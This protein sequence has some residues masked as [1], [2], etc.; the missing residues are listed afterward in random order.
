MTARTTTFLLTDIEGSTRLWE[1]HGDAMGAALEAHDALLTAA[2]EAA[3]GTV[4]KTTGD[5]VLAAFD[6]P[7]WALEAALGGQR[8][9]AGHAW[10]A[11]GPLRV[12][13]AIHSGSVE[14]RD[15][16]YHG[17]ALNRVARLLA[18]GHGGQVLVSGATA[19]LIDDLPPTVELVDRGEH[20]LRDLDRRE[21]VFQVAAA[22][23]PH[24]FPPLRSLGAH[25]TNLPIQ[26]TSFVGREREL[27]ELEALLARSRLVTLVG[28]GGTGKTRLMLQAAADVV[29]R[30]RDGVW[31]VELAPVQDP[32]LV[33][34]E[35]IRALGVQESPGRRPIDTLI[36]FLRDKE[37]LL[38]LDNC[39]HV[40]AAAA[41]LAQRLL[42]SSPT[43][44]LAASSREP[45]GVGGE[46][47]FPV[48]SLSLPDAP[49]ARAVPRALEADGLEVVARS[50][51]VRLFVDRARAT[52]PGFSLDSANAA[53]V[54]GICRRLDGIPL[55][56][57]LAATRVSVLSVQEIEQRL[58]DRF[59]L[60]T[61]GR[62]TAVPRQQTLQALIDW[63]WDLLTEPDRRRLRRLS[64]FAGGWTL[65]AATA[66][67]GSE[68]TGDDT[69]DGLSR[70]VDRSLVVV[71]HEGSTRYRML[72]TIRQYARERLV[73]SG[74]VAELG[75]AHLAYFR[76]LAQEA[77]VG[78][79]GPEMVRWLDRLDADAD[80]VRTA[81]EWAFETD[82]EAALQL[83]VSLLAYWSLRSAGSESADW[84]GRAVDVAKS[85]PKADASEQRE[86]SILVARTLSAAATAWFWSSR[87]AAR[88]LAES[89]LVIA[90]ET[91]DPLAL[92]DALMSLHFA[93]VFG[94]DLAGLGDW[95]TELERVVEE[96][97]DWWRLSLLHA[98]IA[99]AEARVDPAMAEV[100]LARATEAARR[101]GDPASIAFAALARGRVASY[102]R[103][104]AEARPRFVEAM[105]R[106]LEIGDRRW[107][108]IA[109]SE[110]AHG[111][112]RD[113]AVDEARDEYRQTIREWQRLG[114]R[115]A[116]ANQLECL[117]FVAIAQDDGPRAARLLG[118]AE[119]LREVA[120]ATML[121]IE[122]EEYALEMD[123]L[124]A[125]L[126]AASLAT[127]WA[128]G[129]AL[130]PDAAVAF[131]IE[132]A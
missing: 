55:A 9:L 13:M 41:D 112:R 34:Q 50:E 69:L 118:A 54:A 91:G 99:M 57:E 24:D 102:L 82:P 11:T 90:R 60:L 66:V 45:L 125:G 116:I 2:V 84:L 44:T 88:G 108:L 12:R 39:E 79:H 36:D 33:V 132:A 35:V 25:E 121:P 73:A 15:G 87:E 115:G 31:L 128:E 103:H 124:R 29:D 114:N 81:L 59:R 4:V 20:R 96:R 97:G 83:C 7:E 6:K 49:D 14:S 113:G 32:G 38:L 129:R 126:D 8:D 122:L 78:L 23:L 37:L 61:G 67:T 93:A 106:F 119:A 120:L 26:V 75:T 70:L 92:G 63:S 27:G 16:D 110:L 94:G 62:R 130:T 58:S 3:G 68:E 85:L 76:R 71:D 77:D 1:A 65:D 89:A 86:R 47:I 101:S 131:A 52:L 98:G 18:I 28:V 123:R 74:E 80:N 53:S 22:G 21:H 109:R 105:E 107:E 46:V 127:A 117:A 104:L 40:I 64:I 56:L 5:G 95:S 10:P 100:R 17:P 51:A 42:A 19:A 43:L 72:E 30:Y 48:P 111:L